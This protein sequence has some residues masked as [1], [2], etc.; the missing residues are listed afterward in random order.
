MESSQGFQI[1]RA[2]DSASATKQIP[3]AE[4]VLCPTCAAEWLCSGNFELAYQFCDQCG[5]PVES[6]HVEIRSKTDTIQAGLV[7]V[8]RPV[9]L[10]LCP[11]CARK[12]DGTGRTFF[13]AMCLLLGGIAR[14]ALVGWIT[15]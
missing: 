2:I 15:R 11:N 6:G 1:L 9:T 5:A 14:I 13:V 7:A 10:S 8:H 4:S 12:Y 3:A